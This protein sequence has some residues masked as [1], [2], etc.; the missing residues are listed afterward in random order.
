M[1]YKVMPI[2]KYVVYFI[3]VYLFFRHQQIFDTQKLIVIT[4]VLTI[5][6]IVLDQIII[7]SH[8][9]IIE[10][11][12]EDKTDLSEHFEDDSELESEDTDDITLDE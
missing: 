8:P 7:D 11:D 1:N 9:P 4:I 2:Y 3:L 6:M 10:I 5:M 12:F